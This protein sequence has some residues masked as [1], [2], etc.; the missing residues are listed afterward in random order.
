MRIKSIRRTLAFAAAGLLAGSAGVALAEQMQGILITPSAPVAA[1]VQGGTI[2][3][4]RYLAA[5]LPGNGA[6]TAQEGLSAGQ[7]KARNSVSP[8]AFQGDDDASYWRAPGDLYGFGGPTIAG[9]QHHPIFIGPGGSACNTPT[10]QSTWGDVLGFLSD[11]NHSS[12]IHVTDQYVGTNAGGRYPL[13]SWFY[14]TFSSLPQYL[15]DVDMATLAAEAAYLI[16]GTGYGHIYHVFLPPGQDE[17]FFAGGPCYSPD[18]LST[19]AFCAYHGSVDVPGLGHVV[20]TVEPYQDVPGCFV[21]PGTPNGQVEDSTNDVLSH[22]SIETITDP[23]GDAWWNLLGGGM[24][25]QE[26]GDECVFLVVDST[27]SIIGSDPAIWHSA[28]GHIYATQPMYNNRKH[29]CTAGS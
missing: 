2:V 10:C 4:R 29:G 18:N 23:D 12:F 7:I 14:A 22:E 11:L 13:G 6:A 1:A 20:Y 16:N 26:I 19:F 5:R 25:G 8:G 3:H 15:Y 21:R 27:L 24:L 28:N 17:C 9:A